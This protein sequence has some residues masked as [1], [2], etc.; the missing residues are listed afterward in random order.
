MV[1][2]LATGGSYAVFFL[3]PHKVTVQFSEKAVSATKVAQLFP[4]SG[5]GLNATQTADGLRLQVAFGEDVEFRVAVL[6]TEQH[7]NTLGSVV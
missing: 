6:T 1:T 4:A 5:W 2:S 3:R 7:R